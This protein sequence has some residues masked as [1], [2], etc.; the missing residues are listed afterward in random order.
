MLSFV[1]H[2]IEE[3]N[4]CVHSSGRD[5]WAA[6]LDSANSAGENERLTLA[7]PKAVFRTVEAGTRNPNQRC[8]ELTCPPNHSQVPEASLKQFRLPGDGKPARNTPSSYTIDRYLD[9]LFHVHRA[10]NA[11]PR[12]SWSLDASI[13]NFI[14]FVNAPDDLR[15]KARPMPAHRVLD[16]QDGLRLEPRKVLWAV[17]PLGPVFSRKRVRTHRVGGNLIGPT[18][19]VQHPLVAGSTTSIHARPIPARWKASA[20]T[21]RSTAPLRAFRAAQSPASV[22]PH[23]RAVPAHCLL[24]PPPSN[25]IYSLVVLRIKVPVAATSVW[26]PRP[27]AN[28]EFATASQSQDLKISICIRLVFFVILIS[29]SSPPSPSSSSSARLAP[30]PLPDSLTFSTPGDNLA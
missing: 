27:A 16:L 14:E 28:S 23:S 10:L 1:H 13:R 22:L 17:P 11:E 25:P 3:R 21:P 29:S 15:E 5:V 7:A 2:G 24:A 8:R 19:F 6:L 12:E 4:R 20:H 26:A 18:R 30:L 9:L